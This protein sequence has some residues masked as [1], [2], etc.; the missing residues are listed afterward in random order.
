M[1][2]RFVILV[3]LASL[4]L[5]V[6]VASAI[7]AEGGKAQGEQPSGP[8]ETPPAAAK[9]SLDDDIRALREQITAAPADS[10]LRIRI[11]YLLVKKNSLDEAQL[12]FA[13]AL[14]LNPRSHSAQTGE[15]IVLAGKGNLKEAEEMLKAALVMNPDPVRTHYELGMVYEKL[16]DLE[17]ALKEYKAGLRKH[18]QGRK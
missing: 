5:S 9:S 1:N 16:G 6:P 3:L 12:S 13:E 15:G 14:K 11:G 2:I 10:I 8:Q 7:P 17:N 4:S 18:E